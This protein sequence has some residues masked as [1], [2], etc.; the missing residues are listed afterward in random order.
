MLCYIGVLINRRKPVLCI[1]KLIRELYYTRLNSMRRTVKY[2]LYVG[3]PTLVHKIRSRQKQLFVYFFC[4]SV[5][6]DKKKT[7]H[8]EVVH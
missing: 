5:V 7:Y 8:Y 6:L 3:V 2:D 1:R 4:N